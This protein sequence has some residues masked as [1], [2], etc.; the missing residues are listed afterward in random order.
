MSERRNSPSSLAPLIALAGWLAVL[1]LLLRHFP[2][3]IGVAGAVLIALV[4]YLLGYFPVYLKQR[5]GRRR[6]RLL[7]E[8]AQAMKSG[9]F[10]VPAGAMPLG[11]YEAL[12]RALNEWAVRYEQTERLLREERNRIDLILRRMVEGVAVIE[13]NHKIVFCND[14]FA[15]AMGLSGLP[16]A[17]KLLVEV[18]RAAGLLEV[19]DQVLASGETIRSEI[20]IGTGQRQTFAVTCGPIRDEAAP[21]AV[22]VLHDISEIRR[23]EQM[24]RDFVANVSHEFKTPLTAIQG[25]AETLLE[26]ALSDK[27]NGP[28]FARI[29]KDHAHRLNRLTS[30]LLRLS[31]I[32]A[33]KVSVQRS[34]QALAE[35]IQ[36]CLDTV[37]MKAAQ[38]KIAL[39]AGD[40]PPGAQVYGDPSALREIL[41]NL[42]DNAIQYT[43]GG[44]KI[45]LGASQDAHGA[46]LF[47]Q[48]N[49][50][51]IPISEQ[52]RIF[53]R[54]Y[55][56]DDARS[57]E[58]GGTGLGLAI[59]KHLVEAHNGTISVSS[60]L[61]QGATFNVFIPNAG[62]TAPEQN[63]LPSTGV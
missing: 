34:E 32:E 56:V 38:K 14:A 29:I 10:S 9:A 48:D 60:A 18:T 54:F 37:R 33:G 19:V 42:L 15:Q 1:L 4:F 25:F 52:Q 5:A 20:E 59:T 17:G 39:V 50:I 47:V 51:G 22:L 24:R 27:H 36:S 7:T 53:E 43:P 6:L 49:G 3:P 63:D 58:V 23:I 35:L 26:G 62:E 45:V 16:R 21:G 11:E 41:I 12:A 13:P 55:R 8:N 57:R 2:P 30:D 31:L 28:R 44:G 40:I 46:T 61:N